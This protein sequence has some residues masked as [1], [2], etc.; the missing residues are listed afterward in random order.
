M[1]Y[2]TEVFSRNAAKAS[3][4]DVVGWWLYP[5]HSVFSDGTTGTR[6]ETYLFLF[7]E[8]NLSQEVSS[9]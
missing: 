4:S 9:S 3:V 2:Y 8:P 5:R 1:T 7:S 6:S